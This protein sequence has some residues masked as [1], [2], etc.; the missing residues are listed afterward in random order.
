M[1]RAIRVLPLALLASCALAGTEYD[2]SD[3]K[4][5]LAKANISLTNSSVQLLQ[6]SDTAWS[7]DKTGV[8]DTSTSTVTWRIT[9]T[10]G[11]TV[12]G[13]LVVDGFLRVY[14]GGN[15]AA[16]IGNI[17]VNLQTKANGSWHT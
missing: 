9:A 16:T 7:L 17:V 4:A 6:T 2:D 13:H 15:G 5:A 11:A 10:R 14:N 1:R 8:V 3:K 12:G